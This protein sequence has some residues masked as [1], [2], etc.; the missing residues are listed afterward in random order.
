MYFTESWLT[1]SDL[2]GWVTCGKTKFEANCKL[3]PKEIFLSNVGC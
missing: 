2:K 1:D 3:C